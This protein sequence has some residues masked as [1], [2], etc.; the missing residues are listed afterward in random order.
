MFVPISCSMKMVLTLGLAGNQSIRSDSTT[1]FYFIL[2]G[3]ISIRLNIEI[4]PC[5]ELVEPIQ[6]SCVWR[7][8]K[9]AITEVSNAG[10]A[11]EPSEKVKT[12]ASP[13]FALI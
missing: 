5:T 4:P 12:I 10:S 11:E 7:Q 1:T 8:T 13:T 6:E 3:K 9:G 2:T